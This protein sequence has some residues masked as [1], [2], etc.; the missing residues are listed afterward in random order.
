MT[1]EEFKSAI[2]REI[3]KDFI[4]KSNILGIVSM[5][6][7]SKAMAHYRGCNPEIPI[8]E[9]VLEIFNV[10]W[11]ELTSSNRTRKNVI[12]RAI[13]ACYYRSS[14][15]TFHEIGSI[16]NRDHSSIVHLINRAKGDYNYKDV[17][18]HAYINKDDEIK[19]MIKDFCS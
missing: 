18:F 5:Y 19:Q 15:Y 3:D 10:Q 2:N 1:K 12:A 4:N 16:F 9:K 11:N 7:N 6:E 8:K 17:T 14:G 13:L